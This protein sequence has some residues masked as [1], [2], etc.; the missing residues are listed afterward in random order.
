MLPPCSDQGMRNGGEML[1]EI[2]E[3]ILP[4]NYRSSFRV[5][6]R[7]LRGETHVDGRFR[8]RDQVDQDRARDHRGQRSRKAEQKLDEP[9]SHDQAVTKGAVAVQEEPD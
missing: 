4:E 8:L 9:G 2:S 5:I 7:H 1:Q 6:L 3:P